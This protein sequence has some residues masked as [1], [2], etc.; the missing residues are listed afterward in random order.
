VSRTQKLLRG[1]CVIGVVAVVAACSSSK[2]SSSGSSPTSPSSA[3]SQ[4]STG[5]S[6]AQ[7][8]GAPIKVGVVCSCSGPFGPGILPG[9]DVYKAWVNSVNASGG[10]NGHQIQ[11]I[12][13][14]DGS[15]PGTSATDAQTLIS[16]H[17]VAIANMSNFDQ[18]W[19][20]AVQSAGVPVVGTNTTETTFF[21]NPDFYAEG[22]TSDTLI[23]AVIATAKA[24]GATSFGSLYCAEAPVCQ[25]GVAPMKA[26][27]AT[28][29]LTDNF[30]TQ[31][32]I[33]A[34]NYTAQC[35]AAQ[36]AKVSALFIGDSSQVI[37]RVGQNCV[38]QGYN[39]IYVTE[40]EGYGALLQSAPG[41]KDNLWSAYNDLPFWDNSAA[42]QQMNAAVD[43]Y[44]PGL[45]TNPQVFNELSAMSWPSG[46][47]LEDAIKGGGLGA[48]DTPTAAE[49]VK[50][51][52]SL[53]GDTLQG[54][55]PPLT[56]TAGKA[57]P[58]DCWFTSHMTGGVQSLV[59][60]GQLSCATA[61]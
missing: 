41:V 48:S 20:S 35:V 18:T 28:A 37:A 54:W 47:L 32:A 5:S 45:R 9:L 33:S 52:E 17:V 2:H 1:L 42:V 53:K 61:G 16:D 30:N 15:N 36:Q 56:F 25:Q 44:Y 13:E 31:I 46:L 7:A 40:G 55:A 49:V 59:K 57:H 10:I 4:S 22:Q 39:P 60:G 50:G 24:A 29:G 8:T 58:V 19:A 14:D 23:P 6:A 38:Q 26:A 34:P 12:T 51:L 11:L 21:T 3:G 27:A 43:K